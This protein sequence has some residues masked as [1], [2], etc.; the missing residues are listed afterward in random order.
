[1]AGHTP[2]ICQYFENISRK[3]LEKYQ[4]ILRDFVA[5]RHGV[6]ALYRGDRLYYAGLANS[7]RRRLRHHLQDRHGQSWDRF[8]VYLTIGSRHIKELESLVLR[9]VNPPGNR[10][11]GKFVKAEN[12]GPQFRKAFRA[13][14]QQE[15]EY[16]VGSRKRRRNKPTAERR[17]SSSAK[18]KGTLPVLSRYVSASFR[19]KAIYQGKTV[20]AQVHRNGMV[21]V[22][23]TTYR[24]PTGAARAYSRHAVNGWTFWRYERAPGDWVPLNTLRT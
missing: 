11:K 2:L 7:L 23:G 9:M 18:H 19:L 13:Y 22:S 15:L 3:A 16:L 5:G 17:A 6:Y 24:S 8:S 1:M 14:Q 10:Q 21:S 12:L 4:G 20:R